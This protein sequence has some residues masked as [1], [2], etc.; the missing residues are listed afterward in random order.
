MVDHITYGHS[1]LSLWDGR[2]KDNLGTGHRK[3]PAVSERR[4]TRRA[5]S[6]EISKV[7]RGCVEPDFSNAEPLS[8]F[9]CPA[10]EGP[11]SIHGFTFTFDQRDAR[12]RL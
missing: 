3:Q 10:V 2:V 6:F 12:L 9:Y 4:V 11:P 5:V 7:Y 8:K 1:I